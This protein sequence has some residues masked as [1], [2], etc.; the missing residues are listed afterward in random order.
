MGLFGSLG[1]SGILDS[2]W[3]STL[4][5]LFNMGAAGLDSLGLS[6]HGRDQYFAL[7][8]QR[9]FLASQIAAQERALKSNQKFSMDFYNNQ[10][11]TM[12]ANYP[13]LLKMQSDQQFNLWKNQFDV[14]NAYN[15]PSAQV[16]RLMQAGINPAYGNTVSNGVSSMG[17]SSVT[18]PPNISGSPLGGSVSPVGI[19]QGMSSSTLR[20]IGSFMDDLSK[21]D[22][23]GAQKLGQDIQNE[24]DQK[25]LD[26]RIE[27]IALDNKWTDE[28]TNTIKMEYARLVG[29]VNI[30]QKEVE[31]TEKQVAWFD[32]EM[33]AKVADLQSSAKYQKALSELTV[34]QKRLLSETFDDLARYQSLT[35]DT[36]ERSLELSNRYGDAQAIVGMAA[37]IIGA[38]SDLIDVLSPKKIISNVTSNSRT[39]STVNSRSESTNT[40]YNHSY[41]H[42]KK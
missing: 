30:M 20:D 33:S 2:I 13:E 22:L 35:A 24:F 34:E 37:E 4:G 28:Q 6:Q 42:G 40:N 29:E 31:L 39:H 32:K 17:A 41:R 36:L 38:A 18:P 8:A 16:G 19:P 9:E 21:I 7:N 15:N 27:K 10:V 14:E 11:Q 12:L 23:R 26:A 1:L 3:N 25:T 5:G